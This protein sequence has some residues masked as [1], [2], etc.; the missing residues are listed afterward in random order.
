MDLKIVPWTAET[1]PTEDELRGNVVGTAVK[2][3]S[4]V[5]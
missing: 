2:N 3:L 1:P 4:L 5:Q